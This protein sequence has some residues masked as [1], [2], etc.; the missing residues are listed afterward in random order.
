MPSEGVLSSVMDAQAQNARRVLVNKIFTLGFDPAT[1]DT[2]YSNKVCSL[3]VCMYVCYM[4]M[5]TYMYVYTSTLCVHIWT[6]SR[7]RIVE[8]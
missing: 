8:V 6:E 3:Y 5:S 2:R 7:P 4:Y 1:R